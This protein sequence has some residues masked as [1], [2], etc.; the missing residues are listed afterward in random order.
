MPGGFP[1]LEARVCMMAPWATGLRSAASSSRAPCG[2]CP[3][4]GADREPRL[5]A[6]LPLR[7]DGPP[8]HEG[9]ER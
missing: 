9:V 7:V 3:C 1:D 4:E 2:P 8:P 6:L 5:T